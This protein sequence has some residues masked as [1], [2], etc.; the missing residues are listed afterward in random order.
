MRQPTIW[1]AIALMIGGAV[2]LLTDM[3]TTG[4]WIAVITIGI[5]LVAIDTYRH[6]QRHT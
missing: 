5:A 3:G 4:L 1:L 6:R 2:L